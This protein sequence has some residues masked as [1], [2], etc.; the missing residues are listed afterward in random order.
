MATFK[1][2]LD[3]IKIVCT[4]SGGECAWELTAHAMR[5][6]AGSGKEDVD[7]TPGVHA[8]RTT[9]IRPTPRDLQTT[10]GKSLKYLEPAL[11]DLF[12]SKG[13]TGKVRLQM[14]NKL[15]EVELTTE[16]HVQV[17][18]L[19]QQ[20][21]PYP[22]GIEVPT[23]VLKEGALELKAGA[24]SSIVPQVWLVEGPVWLE[25]AGV[26]LTAQLPRLDHQT[27]TIP[28][29][30]RLYL[31]DGKRRLMLLPDRQPADTRN[32]WKEVWRN[33][34]QVLR[35]TEETAWLRADF[36]VG[37]TLPALT[38]E[39]TVK[40][41]K[42]NV[43]WLQPRLP[44]G[45]VKVWLSD[46]P[47]ES[48]VLP[49]E[50]V[51]ELAPG[52]VEMQADAPGV[53]TLVRPGGAATPSTVTYSWKASE[54]SNRE[55]LAL[56]T[57][58]PLVHSPRQVLQQLKQVYGE[59]EGR[60]DTPETGFVSER[61]GWLALYFSAESEPVPSAKPVPA[62]IT[63]P[64]P[65]TFADAKEA[66]G[67]MRIG[68]RRSGLLKPGM[69][70]SQVPWSVQLD[71]PADYVFSLTFDR[72]E[73]KPRL[74][75]ANVSLTGCALRYTGVFWLAGRAPD[76][77][78]ALP[79]VLPDSDAFLPIELANCEDSEA[80]NAPFVL[81]GF[82]AYAPARIA[83]SWDLPELRWSRAPSLDTF[84]SLRV[85]TKMLSSDAGK[86]RGWFRHCR[87]PGV[88]VMPVTR[89]DLSS[90]VP[91]ASRDLE[92]FSSDAA[93][94]V[95][96]GM[97]SLFPSINA[98]E[99][100]AFKSE[101]GPGT[102]ILTMPGVSTTA[103]NA[104]TYRFNGWFTLPMCEERHARTGVPSELEQPQAKPPAITARDPA[105]LDLLGA[106]RKRMGAL[107]HARDAL[108]FKAVT[109]G[110][111]ANV[112]ART[113]APPL[114]WDAKVVVDDAVDLDTAKFGSV[115][116]SESVAG[117][118][119]WSWQGTGNQLLEGP[120]GNAD[121]S[122]AGQVQFAGGG[123]M[124][125]K[126]WSL[127]ELDKGKAIRDGR[128]ILSDK[129]TTRPDFSRRNVTSTSGPLELL[130]T[131]KP[132]ELDGSDTIDWKLSFT[133][134][135]VPADKKIWT[136][137][138]QPVAS[139]HEEG[140]TWSLG[141]DELTMAP[142]ALGSMFTFAPA[143]LVKV[144]FD[145]N[146]KKSV[147]GFEIAG[148]LQVGANSSPE[149]NDPRIRVHLQFIADTKGKYVLFGIGSP[150]AAQLE[151]EL[152]ESLQVL[153]AE[154]PRLKAGL[155]LADGRLVLES[156]ELTLRIFG[157]EL[158]L[159]LAA[160]KDKPSVLTLVN[161]AKKPNPLAMKLSVADIEV[162]VETAT[163]TRLEADVGLRADVSLKVIEKSGARQ[164]A[165]CTLDWFGNEIKFFGERLQT[166][167]V[168]RSLSF[169]GSSATQVHTIPDC[170]PMALNSAS[171]AFVTEPAKDLAF[172][173]VWVFFE[174]VAT[175]ADGLTCSHM[176]HKGADSNAVDEFRFDGEMNLE[177]DIQ[178]PDL[179]CPSLN[180][181]DSEVI[182][183]A[184]RPLV[185]HAMTFRLADHRI[186][187]A[188]VA[189]AAAKGL[190]LAGRPRQ[191]AATWISET[192]HALTWAGGPEKTMDAAAAVQLWSASVLACELES[193]GADHTFTASYRAGSSSDEFPEPGVRRVRLGLFGLFVSDVVPA[194]KALG[195]AWIVV[196]S[197]TYLVPSPTSGGKG[198]FHVH[199]PMVSAL[200]SKSASNTAPAPRQDLRDNLR[201]ALAVSSATHAP[202]SLRMSRHDLL[203][204][205]VNVADDAVRGLG[206]VAEPLDD[207]V[208]FAAAFGGSNGASGA[209]LARGFLRAGNS[210]LE[211]CWHVE[212]FQRPGPS[213]NQATLPFAF[214]RAAVMLS[215]LRKLPATDV[216][217]LSLL[218]A[219]HPDQ[220]LKDRSR[221]RTVRV[222][223]SFKST[224]LHDHHSNADLIVGSAKGLAL[225]P[226]ASAAKLREGGFP[227]L[228]Q[229]ILGQVGRPVFAI[230]RTMS[231]NVSHEV[232][233]LPKAR[234]PALAAASFRLRKSPT[235]PVV[236]S[237]RTWT[238]TH[239]R[240]NLT[241]AEAVLGAR[242]HHEILGAT[243]RS[244]SGA[245]YPSRVSG[246][247]FVARGEPQAAT[248]W[249]QR[250]DELALDSADIDTQD[251]AP[252]ATAGVRIA[253]PVV[254]SPRSLNE[255]L[256]RI[257]P[258]LGTAETPIQSYLP[259]V[260]RD[261]DQSDRVGAFSLARARILW[262]GLPQ[263]SEAS[264]K[265]YA[266]PMSQRWMRIP[267]PVP[268]PPNGADVLQWRRTVGSYRRNNE[269]SIV[270]NGRWGAFF[271][272]L[273]DGIPD[274]M[275]A[276]GSPEAQTTT[277]SAGPSWQGTVRIRCISP[278]GSAADAPRFLLQL[279]DAQR[280]VVRATL[281]HAAGRIAYRTV[282][283]VKDGLGGY[284]VE[285]RPDPTASAIIGA[286][287]CTF[288][289]A[290]DIS[291]KVPSTFAQDTVELDPLPATSLQPVGFHS[292]GLKFRAPRARDYALPLSG[293]TIFFDD[294]EY[295]AMLSK[296]E[297]ASTNGKRRDGQR[298]NLWLD[299]RSATPGET[300]AIRVR[301][302][303]QVLPP[304]GAPATA[305]AR[306][307]AGVKRRGAGGFDPLNFLLADK[308]STGP[309]NL[310]AFVELQDDRFY[311]LPLSILTST[312]ST[313]SPLQAGDVLKLEAE[314][315]ADDKELA[316]L[317]I[318]I[319]DVSVLPAPEAL[320]SLLGAGIDEG[321]EKRG[322]CFLHAATPAAD[323]LAAYQVE[324]KSAGQSLLVRRAHF[325]WEHT[326]SNAVV[327]SFA[328][329]KT[330]L[331]SEST[332]IPETLRGALA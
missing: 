223:A 89:S 41:G 148:S 270:L 314:T 51:L 114:L 169:S 237:R 253:R 10:M 243:S 154:S 293:R 98:A 140:W 46:Q 213:S 66:R 238:Q 97:H 296:I 244:L 94:F 129:K 290:M 23:L 95:L 151:W 276:I 236:D 252:I 159:K 316:V 242:S 247:V 310:V 147:Q 287:E 149:S 49:P 170:A 29:L 8:M 22:T 309:A 178:W 64:K 74:A 322:W 112:E 327:P 142:L 183:F 78:D 117:K 122:I 24:L 55:Q 157:S 27:G 228:L 189:K 280:G 265:A 108:M 25:R 88:Q 258:A 35:S 269:D 182:I 171:L 135:A 124:A 84:S 318:S 6:P 20:D 185:R 187:G 79:Q 299:R 75:E 224:G 331:P 101:T 45:M 71:A 315:D 152:L 321:G 172:G 294:P 207:S 19:Q 261:L 206:S 133:D 103:E 39:V 262:T 72:S 138:N 42:L 58:V 111:P 177:S 214:P 289:L 271:G 192:H 201:K 107:A 105:K 57:K 144:E 291:T 197:G 28:T 219:F 145:T 61:R 113:L 274:W 257:D 121:F 275:L 96:R 198:H 115:D 155:Q 77:D 278:D 233:P 128:G 215:Y 230:L 54:T 1:T 188:F 65:M 168:L 246:D 90:V 50:R 254:P 106:E 302:E 248:V 241:G 7:G 190:K 47:L 217:T 311:S 305:T 282:A 174:L 132:L 205:L 92:P 184:G 212:Q 99:R 259:P 33:L 12:I 139:S 330:H 175:S 131:L 68:L 93:E 264:T 34:R 283:L 239:E 40:Q 273:V 186:D 13:D 17:S 16:Q 225:I 284:F 272:R 306:L 324:G 195:D 176:M 250:N 126:G 37:D 222:E 255:A 196:G 218:V 110:A 328:I 137:E 14:G 56:G 62:G 120:S 43:Q 83:A 312:T 317:Y 81:E 127:A 191:P 267:R 162:D 158:T 26:V 104:A 211:P 193:A 18:G 73:A 163:V 234:P 240:K 199:L 297:A 325:R 266:G 9:W 286:R 202:D 86:L 52:I 210:Y 150:T 11:H 295:D 329:V 123:T 288:E 227:Q 141:K 116:F 2:E 313:G 69:H 181:N 5:V 48:Q 220:S 32:L 130:S 80:S 256:H 251:A 164:N 4:P 85:R 304:S 70:A 38:W 76:G 326:T 167:P 125:V 109:P 292:C 102:A 323:T 100:K 249:L 208:P 3:D 87:L 136:P 226:V 308:S 67:G 44:A 232:L 60:L 301:L 279:L 263:G 36:L 146:S 134:L 320:Y 82:K 153:G 235:F 173:L 260:L 332:Y 91:H 143:A 53:L 156:P 281:S 59:P 307:R 300:M 166:D 63:L 245:V 118:T 31:E 30:V 303:G 285:F 277:A 216:A 203:S 229:S 231:P 221:V 268:L 298:F 180:N 119:T 194:L 21:A 204:T 165:I 200:H 161:R 160:V 209:Q 179:E 15:L 319:K